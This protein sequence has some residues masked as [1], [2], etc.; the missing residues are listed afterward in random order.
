M[1]EVGEL[2]KEM[3][4]SIEVLHE[5]KKTCREVANK[6]QYKGMFS[7]KLFKLKEG[8][9]VSRLVIPSDQ[10]MINAA[11]GALQTQ[12]ERGEITPQEHRLCL[13]NLK[14]QEVPFI[15]FYK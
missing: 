4:E 14:K 15:V 8:D 13:L 3:D 11:I 2:L 12:E 10:M 6:P 1:K 5:F 9:K 7:H